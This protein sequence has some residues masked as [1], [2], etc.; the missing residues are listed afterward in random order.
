MRNN[1]VK[2]CDHLAGPYLVN[3]AFR[4]DTRQG[5]STCCPI[6]DHSVTH[7]ILFVPLGA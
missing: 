3:L 7:S 5:T 6:N 1:V 2:F 4:F